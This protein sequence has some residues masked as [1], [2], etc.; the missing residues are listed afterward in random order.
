MYKKTYTLLILLLISSSIFA[1]YRIVVRNNIR[2][3]IALTGFVSSYLDIVSPQGLFTAIVQ[4][5]KFKTNH[6][7]SNGHTADEIRF[8]TSSGI[9]WGYV[10]LDINGDQTAVQ[11]CYN[12]WVNLPANKQFLFPTDFLGCDINLAST[13]VVID[14]SDKIINGVLYDTRIVYFI[15]NRFMNINYRVL[16]RDQN[17]NRNFTRGA[18][19][20]RSD[21]CYPYPS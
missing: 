10:C 3:D 11:D 21:N 20:T 18:L 13:D 4:P 7:S 17:G 19:V 1:D 9:D 12:S 5:L 2:A 8:G 15:I 6:T 16:R 14:T